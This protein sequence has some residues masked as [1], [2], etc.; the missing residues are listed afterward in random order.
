MARTV[1][2]SGYD[3]EDRSATWSGRPA[4]YRHNA[5]SSPNASASGAAATVS[6]SVSPARSAVRRDAMFSGAMSTHSGATP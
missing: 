3:P 4:T 5:G 6:T 2:S 1:V